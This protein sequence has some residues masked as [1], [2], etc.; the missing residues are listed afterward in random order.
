M[1]VPAG[2]ELGKD[3]ANQRERGKG[4]R[5]EM[6]PRLEKGVGPRRHWVIERQKVNRQAIVESSGEEVD[7]HW[8][9]TLQTRYHILSQCPF[10]P[11][12]LVPA[13]EGIRHNVPRPH[14]EL[15]EKA[16]LE[17]FGPTKQ[18]LSFPVEGR[19]QRPP[20][21]TKIRQSRGVVR[22]DPHCATP[23]Q[24]SDVAQPQANRSQLP[25]VDGVADLLRRPL[26]RNKPIEVVRPHP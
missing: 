22:E 20:L 4:I 7:L 23:Q 17:G 2:L 24:R 11:D 5:L 9:T 12:D 26:A 6:V 14:D 10:G 18:K 3:L 16:N 15:G 1:S 25:E 19:R 13:T 21:A 8:A